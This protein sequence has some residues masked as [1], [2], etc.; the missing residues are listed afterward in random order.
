MSTPQRRRKVKIEDGVSEDYDELLEVEKF[1][2]Q[3]NK[4]LQ[5]IK[6]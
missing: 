6:Q 5:N 2:Q 3:Q 1:M 4:E